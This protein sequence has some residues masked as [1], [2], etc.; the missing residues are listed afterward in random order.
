MRNFYQIISPKFPP[1]DHQI[2]AVNEATTNFME[3]GFHALF[4]E[5]GTGKTKTTIDSWMALVTLKMSDGLVICAPKAILSVWAEEELPKHCTLGYVLYQWDGRKSMRAQKE[6]EAVLMS[7]KPAV[8][9]VNT[10]SFQTCPETMRTRVRAFL[11]QRSCLMAVDESSYI[12]SA[13][14]NRTKNISLAGALAKFRT[15]LTGTEITNSPLDLY[16]QMEFLKKGF[17]G[18][19]SFFMFRQHYAILVDQYGAGGRTFKKVVGF[20]RVNELMDKVNPHASRALKKDCLDLPPK[21]YQNINVEM[22]EPIQTAYMQLKK[23]LATLIDDKVLT[24]PN[25]IALFTK[26]RQI[27]GGAVKIEDEVQIIDARPPKLQAL[28]ADLSDTDEQAVIWAAF[29][30]EIELIAYTLEAEGFGHAVRFYGQESQETR[31]EAKREF[32]SG[33][34]RFIVINPQCGAF[35][36]N[37]QQCH[38]MYFY[39]RS[40]RPADNWQ[41]EDRIHRS[42]QDTACVYKALITKGTVDERIEAL[43]TAK[44]DIRTQFQ[45]MTIADMYNMV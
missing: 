18:V 21:I 5:M 20:Q 3:Q 25:K 34:A 44:T 4:M 43:L 10:E 1:Y 15:I 2:K 22:S 39:S 45:D 29:T 11:K 7:K 26:F 36:L 17:F 32:Q 9:L 30:Q 16:S 38:L 35:G 33:K 41:G 19:K 31:D 42:G 27:T 8:F 28:L 24:V 23:H 13:D 12:K 40:L 37:L 6:F 14:A